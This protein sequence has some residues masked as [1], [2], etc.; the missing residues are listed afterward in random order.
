MNI[1]NKFLISG[2][3][4]LLF[5]TS[6]CA[7]YV[8]VKLLKPSEFNIGNV[9]KL[10][11]S[12]FKFTGN[13]YYN[14]DNSLEA[15]AL[16]AVV[17]TI[18]GKEVVNNNNRY[19]A[20]QVNQIFNQKLLANGHFKII[21]NIGSF[22]NNSN[23][24]KADLDKIR[25]STGAE[26]LLSGSG[27]YSI[28]DS[29]RWVDDITYRN[30]IKI[31]N[32]KYNLNRRIDTSLSYKVINALNGEIVATK[33][34]SKSYTE[35]ASG[36][37]QDMAR[38]NLRDWRTIVSDHVE[39]LSD[40]SVKQIAPYYIFEDREIKE[41][42]SPLMKKAFE[43]AK[44]ELWNEAKTDWETILK[45][46]NTQTNDSKEDLIYASY[47]MGIYNEVNGNLSKAKEF[48]SDCYNKGTKSECLDASKRI[49]R[50]EMEIEKLKSQGGIDPKN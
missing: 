32:K 19:S 23:F 50:R 43:L 24:T 33:L 7:T 4:V 48:F 34:N 2:S 13:S 22:S 46:N 17:N 45:N 16:G 35:L 40:E 44:K 1:I 49:S 9:K 6:G 41:G 36:N 42:K 28:S 5:S 3:L 20:S 38:N 14:E 11:V 25:S 27:T 29:G 26:A 39:Q 10:A 30:G 31:T 15:I 47:N 12:D 21:D 18:M 37:D 8:K